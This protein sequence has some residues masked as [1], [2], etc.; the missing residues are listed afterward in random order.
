MWMTRFQV[1]LRPLCLGVKYV[2]PLTRQRPPIALYQPPIWV[3]D[4]LYT[5]MYIYI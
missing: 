5:H 1:N 4:V 2:I 3:V